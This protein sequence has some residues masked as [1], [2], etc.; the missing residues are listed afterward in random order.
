MDAEAPVPDVYSDFI[1]DIDTVIM[2]FRTYHQIT[3]E[4]SP[5][6][7]V[8]EGLQ[9]YVI[10]HRT[11][12]ALQ[13]ITFTGESPCSLVRTL[14]TQKGRGIWICGGPSIIQ[15]LIQ[16]DLIDRYWITLIPIL[17]GQGTRLFEAGNRTIPLRLL[18]TQS[19]NGM[20]D[21]IYERR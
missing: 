8:Y 10:T 13:G 12:P 19:Y 14:Q 3:T 20:T 15:P 18:H 6:S 11:L 17:L 1:K 16:E 5:E 21:L 7:W 4:L 9:S 2:G